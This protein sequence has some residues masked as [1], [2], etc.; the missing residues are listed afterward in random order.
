M[1]DIKYYVKD[2]NY[3]YE[4]SIICSDNKKR[5]ITKS[6][7]RTLK[8]A[9]EAAEKSYKKR[10]LQYNAIEE[11]PS[12]VKKFNYTDTLLEL[13]TVATI[14]GIGVVVAV[15]GSKLINN[16]KDK[17]SL[18]HGYSIEEAQTAPFVIYPTDC[19][20][21]DIHIIIRSAKDETYAVAKVTS[22][23]L[24]ML[25]ISNEVVN[26]DNNYID[27]IKDNLNDRTDIIL[28]NIDYGVE[29]EEYLTIMNDS[30]NK[31]R[32]PSDVL[33]ACINA[34]SKDYC[35]NTR[36][37][38]GVSTK[39]GWR[40]ETSIERE[41]RE[42]EL[43][44]RVTQ[45]TV[46]FPLC[47]DNDTIRNDA[48][49][50]IVEGLLRYTYINKSDRYKN[51]YH[52][53]KYGD[54]ISFVAEDYNVS[55][56]FIYDNSYINPYKVLTVGDTLVV[57]KVP[58]AATDHYYVNNPLTTSDVNKVEATYIP[59]EVQKGDTLSKIAKDYCVK[60][61]DIIISS[62]NINNI[63][64]GELIYIPSFTLYLTNQKNH[65]EILNSR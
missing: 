40:L 12:K 55:S 13:L 28:I 47:I 58:D 23:Q 5:H 56:E 59:Y 22:N 15:G 61:E 32:Y 3:C 34:S 29:S 36:L 7:F 49:S 31:K 53:V 54:N 60:V 65:G 18:I 33:A 63:K 16:F 30:Y 50:S 21:S 4:Y 24:T 42:N 9:Q 64:E 2:N 45:L 11:L 41:L 46:D 17:V 20:F 8:E 52:S 26:K 38:S 44:N 39:N 57:G 19:D 10:S 62:D 25:G 37:L 6:G 48:A 43:K 27:R 35:F 51:I 1:K 14:G